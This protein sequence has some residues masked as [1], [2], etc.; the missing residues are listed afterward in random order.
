MT[1]PVPEVPE[2]TAAFLSNAGTILTSAPD[3]REEHLMR[4]RHVFNDAPV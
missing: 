2:A 1:L 3:G 4:S